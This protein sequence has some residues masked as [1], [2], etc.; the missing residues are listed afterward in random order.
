MV[1]NYKVE[2]PKWTIM[3]ILF[4]EIYVSM[5]AI[6]ETGFAKN[7]LLINTLL[8]LSDIVMLIFFHLS[9]VIKTNEAANTSK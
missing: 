9:I 7:L 8:F 1:K 4:I 5:K 6:N 2:S 3:E